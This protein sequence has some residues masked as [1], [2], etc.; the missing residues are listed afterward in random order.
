MGGLFANHVDDNTFVPEVH[1]QGRV[2]S[3]CKPLPNGKGLIYYP[4]T[5]SELV[6]IISAI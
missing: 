4:Y 2:L 3:E 1:N 5:A 6:I